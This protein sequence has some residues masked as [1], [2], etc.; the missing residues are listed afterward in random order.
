MVA[1]LFNDGMAFSTSG[2]QDNKR[3]LVIG[4]S[5][6]GIMLFML[7]S[8]RFRLCYDVLGYISDGTHRRCECASQFHVLNDGFIAT[9]ISLQPLQFFTHQN[10]HH[11]VAVMKGAR[12]L[13][14]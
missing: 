4:K 14:C 3:V 8:C 11:V 13:M 1:V 6:S 7:P 12:E 2:Y 10:L 5:F 9:Y